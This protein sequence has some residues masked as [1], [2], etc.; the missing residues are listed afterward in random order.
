MSTLS[1]CLGI[2]CV[3]YLCLSEKDAPE[4]VYFLPGE[5]LR[6]ETEDGSNP[7]LGDQSACDQAVQPDSEGYDIPG[8][9]HPL[10]RSN[11]RFEVNS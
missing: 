7:N 3:I 2:V 10:S 1:L 6:P 8:Y 11:A 5:P 4:K 9:Q